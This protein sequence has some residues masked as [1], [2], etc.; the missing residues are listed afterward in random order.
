MSWLISFAWAYST[1]EEREPR[2]TNLNEKFLP[3]VGFKHQE[4]SA[5]EANSLRVDLLVEINVDHVLPECTIQITCT[6]W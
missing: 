2:I 4:S 6:T 3:T 5:S 1:C